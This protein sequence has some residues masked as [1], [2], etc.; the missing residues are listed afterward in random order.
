[1]VRPPRP[2]RATTGR[3]DIC[4]GCQAYHKPVL[5][6]TSSSIYLLVLTPFLAQCGLSFT[7][8]GI[9]LS[10]AFLL[11]V[12]TPDPPPVTCCPTARGKRSNEAKRHRV[13]PARVTPQFA[14]LSSVDDNSRRVVCFR[15]NMAGG[16]GKRTRRGVAPLSSQLARLPRR[17]GSAV[18]C[19][20]AELGTLRSRI[21]C[22]SGQRGAGFFSPVNL[23]RS[24]RPTTPP[25]FACFPSL[26][27]NLSCSSP[28]PRQRHNSRAP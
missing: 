21:S 10:P 26:L 2:A 7:R 19:H 8:L 3:K 1:L 25:G 9:Q 22:Q 4:L 5:H 14:R 18:C 11:E 24:S 23:R 15:C 17:T 28:T 6:G 13:G 27:D 20:I 12:T 16:H